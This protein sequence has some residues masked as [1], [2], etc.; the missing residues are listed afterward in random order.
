M[1]RTRAKTL[2]LILVLAMALSSGAA[3][4]SAAEDD[5]TADLEG[6][7]AQYALPALAASVVKAGVPVAIGATGVR[8]LGTDVKVTRDDRFHLGSDTKAMTATLAGM[9]VEEGKLSWTS[10]VGEV[11]GPAAA[12]AGLAPLTPG[13]AAIRLEQLLSHTSGI[14]SDTE[15]MYDLY[16]APSEYDMSM[17]A[18]R[19]AIVSD[20]GAKNTPQVPAGTPF[21]YAN[22]GYLTAGAMIETAAGEAWESLITRRIFDPLQLKTAGLGPQATPGRLDAAAGHLVADDGTVTPMPWGPAADVPGVLGPAGT[23]HMSIRDFAAWAA[24]NAGAGKR[25]PALVTATTLAALHQPRVTMDIANPKPGT[26]KSGQY[27]FGWGIMKMDWT[28]RPIL[29]HNGSNTKNLAT[30]FIDPAIDLAIVVTT[31]FPGEVADKAL[32]DACKLLFA[33]YGAAAAA[34][35]PERP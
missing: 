34:P 2:S 4:V 22:L 23:A 27:A 25:G 19:L 5:L 12:K 16:V 9:L 35:E 24:W 17:A 18:R 29:T 13:F 7:R 6:I 14:P 30:V 15:A 3:A 1:V 20:W 28:P 26:P 11:L 10:T 32:L 8:A 31:N 33:R 21:Q